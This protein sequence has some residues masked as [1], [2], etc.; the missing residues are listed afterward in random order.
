MSSLVENDPFGFGEPAPQASRLGQAASGGRDVNLLALAW[1]NR[2][3]LLL[4]TL[5]GGAAAWAVLQRVTPRYTS[6][7]RLYVERTLPQLLTA[8]AQI[9]QSA[10]YLYTQAELIRS[11]PVLA[12]VAEAPENANLETFR[13]VDNRVA[14]LRDNIAVGVG[15]QD[16]IINVSA[17]LPSAEDAAQ[18]VNSVV[19][20][21]V[22]QYAEQRKTNAVEV[23][24]ILRQE[25]HKRDAE[26]AHC[27]Q[28]LDDFR[29][30]H[31][32]L[33]VQTE[34]GNV[35]TQ[36]FASLATEL[37]EVEIQLLQ[38]K[39]LYNRV[40]KMYDTPK[41]RPFLLDMAGSEQQALRDV[42]LERQAQEVEQTLAAERARWGEGHPRIK[43]LR[44]SLADLR[45][46]ISKKQ[47]VV[48]E[49]YVESV[50]QEYELLDQK[51]GE[52]QAAYDKSFASATQASSLLVQQASLQEAYD[53]TAKLC[54]ILDDRIKELNLTEGI[55]ASLIVNILE[56][57]GPAPLPSYPSQARFLAAGLL[58]GGLV[59]FGLAWLRE[60]MD[61]RLKSVDEVSDVVQLSVF[62]VVP[63]ADAAGDRSR[64]GQLMVQA[65]RSP[66][67][68]AVR[69]LRTALHFG[70]A[71]QEAK[72]VAVTSPLPGDGK[73]TVA[74]N[75]AIAMAQADQ[76]VLLIDADLR[77][78]SQHLIFKLA[79]EK[80]LASVLSA[81]MPA[82]EAIVSSVVG[83]LDVLP[84]GPLPANPVELLNN[85]YFAEL[86]QSLKARYDKI[87]ID[88][89]PVLPV[90]DAR[91]IAAVSDATLLV[92]RAERS[93]RRSA[94]GAR[95]EL[96]RVRATRLGV[97]LNGVPHRKQEAYGYGASYGYGYGNQDGY[98][99]YPVLDEPSDEDRAWKKSRALIAASVE[100]SSPSAS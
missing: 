49:A 93:T 65:P 48:I 45:D 12:A 29:Q 72:I 64:A 55:D 18:L 79:P 54:D 60:L 84:C 59:G 41:Q 38:A 46:K 61:H 99:D 6:V 68:E 40:K 31:M 88:S 98:G 77:K 47:A 9:A 7:S 2:W 75:L 11:T 92:L 73:T 66:V 89:P 71:G 27:R 28:A 23:L 97:V 4:M 85:G 50:R 86:L 17:E 33:A 63:Y 42:E 34:Q 8:E 51:R 30:E 24:N 1:R 95:N 62:G 25:K 81:R 32:E 26:L 100:P 22:T 91:I 56:V 13:E 74:S 44:E 96:W 82:G 10:T 87:I 90:A 76:R 20:A 21:Y 43:L 15:S 35:V 19:D 39:A 83:A 80:G 53:R 94:L 67:A 52:L 3:L 14:F 58:L 69:T 16:D 5:I 36:R 57:A 37:N 70:L 78:P